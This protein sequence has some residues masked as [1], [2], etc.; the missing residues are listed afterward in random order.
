MSW[1]F[2]GAQIAVI[3]V[4]GAFS[5]A[6]QAVRHITRVGGIERL[7]NWRPRH[8]LVRGGLNWCGSMF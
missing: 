1:F 6:S 3:P 4:E 5:Q 7:R 8:L 2:H